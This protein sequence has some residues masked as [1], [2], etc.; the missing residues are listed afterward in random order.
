MCTDCGVANNDDQ[1][2]LQRRKVIDHDK[3]ARCPARPEHKPNG[4]SVRDGR[5]S[6]Q[7]SA[8]S[9]RLREVARPEVTSLF[10]FVVLVCGAGFYVLSD[11]L[12]RWIMQQF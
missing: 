3:Q 5:V 9:P 10:V 7:P 4:F 11:V 1:G 12:A 8:Q 6:T 2:E